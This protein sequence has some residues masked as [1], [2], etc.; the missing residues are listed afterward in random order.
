[1][2]MTHA[3]PPGFAPARLDGTSPWRG[4]HGWTCF[5]SDGASHCASGGR[6]SPRAMMSQFCR[7][8]WR[9]GAVQVEQ[10]PRNVP[11][12]G[13]RVAERPEVAKARERAQLCGRGRGGQRCGR[14][15]DERIGRFRPR[16]TARER[17]GAAH[18][19][20]ERVHATRERQRRLKHRRLDVTP[21][22]HSSCMHAAR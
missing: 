11:C 19:T 13:G 15:G 5:S 8:W 20:Q 9:W 22:L 3:H 21:Q 10:L 17:H 18:R 2:C 1:M 12:D 7:K 6:R 14:I 16:H 4:M